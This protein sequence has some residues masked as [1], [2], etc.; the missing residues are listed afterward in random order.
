MDGHL[1]LAPADHG[2]AGSRHSPPYIP[3]I[4]AVVLD[5]PRGGQGWSSIPG[6]IP[7]KIK[8]L[9]SLTSDTIWWL[10]VPYKIFFEQGFTAGAGNFRHDKWFN[11][12]QQDVL[13]ETCLTREAPS[14]A[15]AAET[16]SFTAETI[17]LLAEQLAESCA[18]PASMVLRA[19]SLAKGL[20]SL[21]GDAVLV[22]EE[23]RQ[24][25]GADENSASFVRTAA[26]KT[27]KRTVRFT[28]PR[29]SYVIDVLNTPVPKGAVAWA[30]PVPTDPMSDIRRALNPVIADIT[31][32]KADP[33]RAGLYNFSQAENGGGLPRTTAA[34]PEL[35]ALDGFA[36]VQVHSLWA[37]DGYVKAI[38]TLPTAIRSFLRDPGCSVSWSGG[39]LAMELLRALMAPRQNRHREK[40][41]TWRGVFL[42]ANA[43]VLAFSNAFS[44]SSEGFMPAAYGC[45]WM[46]VQIP[47]DPTHDIHLLMAALRLG[48]LPAPG[49][50]APDTLAR[51]FSGEFGEPAPEGGWGTGRFMADTH[52]TGRGD[53]VRLADRAP[54]LD[55]GEQ[56]ALFARLNR[57]MRRRA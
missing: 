41:M 30:R 18:V 53:L 40:C 42:K 51:A 57:E 26:N 15:D 20:T 31:I 19:H 38:D 16:L 49:A 34:H 3:R 28:R 1:H 54:L 36:V 10:N 25:L 6:G 24:K 44:L 47:D 33:R 12:G 4:G 2:K 37:G 32:S 21:I 11:I 8:A 48:Y 39:I 9:A 46:D 56:A 14:S 22:P 17:A 35:I 7:E 29:L 13:R 52:L 55:N 45:G 27:G 43:R 50:F 23:F 5:T